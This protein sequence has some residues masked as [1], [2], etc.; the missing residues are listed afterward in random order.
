ME[1]VELEAFFCCFA[2]SSTLFRLLFASDIS[3]FFITCLVPG[4]MALEIDD[5]LV[6]VLTGVNVKP[7]FVYYATAA[8]NE[9]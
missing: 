5:H 7:S 4:Y 3:L 1:K 2:F 9:K 6:Q 8:K